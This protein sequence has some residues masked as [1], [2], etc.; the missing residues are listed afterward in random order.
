MARRKYSPN[1]YKRSK[2]GDPLT[3]EW[4]IRKAVMYGQK[5]DVLIR[6]VD[7]KKQRRMVVD[8]RMSP[9]IS[10]GEA[11]KFH[12]SRS[13][14]SKAMDK[15]L[16]HKKQKKVPDKAWKNRPGR[17]DIKGIDNR[18]KSKRKKSKK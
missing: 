11:R 18:K 1:K 14:K 3:E 15:S 10:W 5:R 16:Q 2:P 4:T 12:N 13:N 9:T 8:K 17:S 7:G 6:K